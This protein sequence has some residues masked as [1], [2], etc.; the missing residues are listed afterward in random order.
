MWNIDM[1]IENS[2][3]MTSECTDLYLQE[4]HLHLSQSWSQLKHVNEF[5]F[6]VPEIW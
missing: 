4:A 5:R 2:E 1:N 3:K 6:I